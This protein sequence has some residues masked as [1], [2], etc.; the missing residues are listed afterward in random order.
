MVYIELLLGR[1][2]II[3]INVMGEVKVFGIYWLLVF[4]LVFYVLYCV[5]GI[6]DIG[7]LCDICVVRD[8]KEIVCVDVYDYI[9]KG[10]L[11]DNICLL[12]G[13]VI[14]VFFY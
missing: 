11:M 10:K 6:S 7:S 13:D 2:C 3:M 12:E 4:V 9:M 1:I 8:G 14:L 5:G